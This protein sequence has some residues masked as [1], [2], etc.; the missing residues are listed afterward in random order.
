MGLNRINKPEPLAKTAL[1]AI[2]HSILTNE[3]TT[4]V[5]YNEKSLAKDLG[6][7]RTPVREAL[8]ELSSK[9]LV[10]FLPQKGVI[11]NTFSDND[12]E[13][14]FEIRTAL[15]VFSIKKTC[16]NHENLDMSILNEYLAHQK[17]A[18]K[19][20]DANQ[21]MEADRRFHIGFTTLTN[22]DYLMDMMNDIRDIMH[23]MGSKALSIDGRMEVVV[24]EH[25]NILKAVT[26]GDATQAVA[27]MVYHL[28][29]SK[30]AVN[31]IKEEE[32]KRNG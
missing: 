16:Q 30:K 24:T 10:K 18:V 4:G 14:V 23:L 3:L 9:R 20:K 26:K 31:K 15:E 7:S 6:I 29:C 1:K 12:I 22:N 11:I 28:E 19:L 13:D 25:E 5:V 8:L 21:F 32:E 27:K 17:K 2:R